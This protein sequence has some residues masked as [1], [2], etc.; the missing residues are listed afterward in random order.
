MQL[1]TVV[2]SM[3]LM[4]GLAA[5]VPKEVTAREAFALSDSEF[6]ELY[7]CGTGK[8]STDAIN[9]RCCPAA[10]VARDVASVTDDEFHELYCCGAGKRDGELNTRCCPRS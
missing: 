5:A 7:C 6:S 1:N 8:R 9:T 2:A 4:L 10:V 3:T